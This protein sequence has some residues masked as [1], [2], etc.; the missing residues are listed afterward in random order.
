VGDIVRAFLLDLSK[1]QKMFSEQHLSVPI[2]YYKEQCLA[3]VNLRS[4]KPKEAININK[5][6]DYYYRKKKK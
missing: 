3:R 1:Y 4:A 5:N 2:V 6:M